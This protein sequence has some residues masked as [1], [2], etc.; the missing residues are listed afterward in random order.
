MF[1]TSSGDTLFGGTYL[2]PPQMIATLSEVSDAYRDRAEEI[3]T[4]AA[5][6]RRLERRP[7]RELL[8]TN[9]DAVE[10][11]RSLLIE[12][13]DPHN[14]GFGSAPKLPHP[15]RCRSRSHWPATAT[16]SSRG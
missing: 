13:F 7:E 1:L 14:G 5:T 4:R 2:D 12:R 10:H 15:T 3:R 8:Q 16:K 11:F 6:V 9:R